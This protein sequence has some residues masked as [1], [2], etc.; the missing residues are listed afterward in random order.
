VQPWNV[1]GV[2]DN[3]GDAEPW[4]EIFNSG[5][6]ALAT[7]DYFLSDDYANLMRWPFPSSVANPNEF[8]LIWVDDEAVESTTTDWHTNFRLNPTNGAVV[9]SRLVDGAPQIVDYINYRD[10]GA[11]RS[12][13]SYPDGQLSFRRQFA[14]PTPRATNNAAVPPLTAFINEWMPANSSFLA[15]PADGDYDDWFELYNPTT[16]VINLAG[17]TLTDLLS[18][19]TKF[20]IPTGITIPARGF[21]LVWADEEQGQTQTNGDLHV[22]FRL[23]QGGEAIGLFDPAGRAIDAITFGSQTN[24][25]SQGRW[26]DGGGALYYMRTP[27]PRAANQLSTGVVYL[28]SIVFSAPNLVTLTWQAEPGRI[29]RVQYKN[30]LGEAEWTNLPGDIEA[31]A[32]T[33]SK[34]DSTVN[35]VTQRF[36]RILLFP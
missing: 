35:G 4:I 11:D 6:N 21:L 8:R 27:T 1:T 15:D 28:N 31:L 18:D 7:T 2:R 9:L 20:T 22:N 16:N 34:T 30:D 19:P 17:Y 26:P 12:Y 32:A 29:Y 5:S 36:Y 25:I 33:A 13:G 24:N 14:Y 10:V 3:F 23:S